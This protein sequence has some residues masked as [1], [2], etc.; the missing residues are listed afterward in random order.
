MKCR[1]RQTKS[2]V[3][4]ERGVKENKGNL[5]PVL[6]RNRSKRSG[7]EAVKLHL[8]VSGGTGRTSRSATTVKNTRCIL[9]GNEFFLLLHALNMSEICM[10]HNID[11]N[12]VYET[13]LLGGKV[14]SR[15]LEVGVGSRKLEVTWKSDKV[16]G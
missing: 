2:K 5:S 11:W 7:L 8:Q 9:G 15:K 10:T 6:V 4:L 14:G 1:V 3:K 13:T 16:C 12:A